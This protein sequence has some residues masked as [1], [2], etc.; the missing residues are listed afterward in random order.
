MAE[1]LQGKVRDEAL[2]AL[3]A[4]GWAHDPERDA[5]FKEFRFG[6][7][8]AAWG[9]MSQAALRAEKMNHH[10]EWFNVYN[11]VEVTLTTHDAGGLSELDVKLAQIMDKLADQGGA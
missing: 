1:K 4:G 8:V 2:Q 10:P 5:L 11:R 6:N 9:F 7:F 3:L